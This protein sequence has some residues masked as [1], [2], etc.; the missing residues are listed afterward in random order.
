MLYTQPVTYDQGLD[1]ARVFEPNRDRWDV[2][3]FHWGSL[4]S[5]SSL[6]AFWILLAPFAMA[7]VA[8]WMSESPNV[9]SRIWIRVAG[10]SLTGIFFSQIANMSLDIPLAAGQSPTAAAWM[11][12]AACLVVVGGLGW[13]STQS[14]FR[15]LTFVE[16]MRHLFWPTVAAM[17]PVRKELAWDDPAGEGKVV[18][19]AMWT[20]HSIV[21]RLRRIHLTFGMA[22]LSVVVARMTDGDVLGIT[23]LAVAGGML[24]LVAFTAGS[25]AMNRMVLGTT[26]T[27]P[28]LG[29]GVLGWSLYRLATEGLTPG[30]TS[31]SDQLTYEVALVLG[32]SAGAGL[33]G[34][35]LTS[36]FKRGWV[37]LGL[38]TIG[39]LIGGTL[40]LTGAMLVEIYLTESTSTRATFDGGAAFVTVGMLGLVVTIAI[41]LVVAMAIPKPGTEDPPLRRGILRTRHI[42]MVAALYGAAVGAV[43]AL[44][45]CRGPEAGCSQTNIVMPEQLLEDPENLTVL[46][47]LPFDPASLLGWAKIL[48]VAV[49]AVLIV[50]SVGGG[51]L[52]GQDSRRKVGILWDLGSFWP[53]WFHPLGPPGYGPYAVTRMQ[54][55]MSEVKPDVLAA[56]SQGSLIAA[57]AL[58]L[59]DEGTAPRLFITYGSQLGDLYPALFP[60]VGLDQLVDA[61]DAQVDGNWVNLWRPSDAIGGQVVT[62][63]GSRNWKVV[64]GKGHSRYELT[65]EFCAARMAHESRDVERPPDLDMADCWDR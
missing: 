64:T 42:L 47:G 27:T 56:H 16:R 34:E 25:A 20:V 10:L 52:N 65:P 30:A 58:C 2:K 60:A 11:Y 36:R 18:G 1:L 43:G 51:L 54:T 61:A 3:A 37:S 26:A 55:V 12:A 21:H 15:P 29:L 62:G 4:T 19:P 17:N 50:R 39:T 31:V 53:R 35:L 28:L 49:P 44:L 33:L 24:V 46:F 32:V 59:S 41:A 45:S 22:L 7:N 57:V 40:G 5:K 9:W 48:M 14:T 6:S 63:L 38:L 13:L 8:G 23:A